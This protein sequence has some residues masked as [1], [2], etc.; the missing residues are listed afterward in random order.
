M[1]ALQDTLSWVVKH[2]R[3]ALAAALL[4]VVFGSEGL[5]TQGFY[6]EAHTGPA[7]LGCVCV[8]GWQS[9][10]LIPAVA[11]GVRCVPGTSPASLGL[12]LYLEQL[13]EVLG[14]SL[15]HALPSTPV[16]TSLL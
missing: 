5:H 10:H 4:P 13:P 9:L 16:P 8:G 15:G 14:T 3:R 6:W 11:Q 2:P 1:L 7:V 12:A